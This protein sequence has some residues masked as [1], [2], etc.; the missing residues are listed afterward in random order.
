V[1]FHCSF[2][3]LYFFFRFS[4]SPESNVLTEMSCRVG[5]YS[6]LFPLKL[7]SIYHNLLS[8]RS[9]PLRDI[10]LQGRCS[11]LSHFVDS[12]FAICSRHCNEING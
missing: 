11:S 1:S 7:V 10:L 5:N 3:F 12:I 4:L 2:S 9:L 6:T 8:F